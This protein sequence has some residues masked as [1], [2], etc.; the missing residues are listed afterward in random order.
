MAYFETIQVTSR[1]TTA[2]P[3]S[4][5]APQ[6][7]PLVV[8]SVFVLTVFLFCAVY[9]A[10]VR[11]VDPQGYFGTGLFPVLIQDARREKIRL[12]HA[13][14]AAGPVGGLVLGSSRS[15][16]LE[17][18]LLSSLS[19]RR[20][21]NFGVE[22]ARAEDY[23]AI[24]RWVRSQGGHPRIVVV[25]LDVEA[26]HNDDV[27]ETPFE[28][29]EDLQYAWRGSDSR[30]AAV[31]RAVKKYKRSLG[32]SRLIDVGKSM[33]IAIGFV[34]QTPA[35]LL[36]ADGYLRYLRWKPES[37]ATCNEAMF[38]RFRNMA[39][40][41]PVRRSALAQLID[42]ARADG[43]VVKL[44]LTPLHPATVAY[45]GPR[46]PYRARLADVRAYLDRLHGEWSFDSYDYSD[47]AAYGG[48]PADWYNCNHM[49]DRDTR[50][51]VAGVLRDRR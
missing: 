10:L 49:S 26:L 19:G 43:A 9:A 3:A 44:W 51:V 21:F 50:L 38:A 20:V 22:S 24:Y 6:R 15:M 25:G 14:A 39:G 31:F 42:E 4:V 30:R 12:Y 16:K 35:T 23:L 13:Y 28:F 34:R 7:P 29:N 36:D 33:A 8:L 41:S 5:P 11:L 32:A 46:S 1:M 37:L 47:P 48:E 2:G 17:P 40:L 45:L 18:P 27:P